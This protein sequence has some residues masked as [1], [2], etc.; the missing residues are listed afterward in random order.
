MVSNVAVDQLG[1]QSAQRAAHRGRL[2]QDGVAVIALG[3]GS[4]DSVDLTSD[5]A[6]PGEKLLAA[7][8]GDV[9]HCGYLTILG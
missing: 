1:H 7:V 4:L 6:H 8:V 2:L 3:N 9:G 5:A